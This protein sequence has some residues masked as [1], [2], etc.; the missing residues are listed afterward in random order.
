M[1]TTLSVHIKP[2]GE[3]AE[4]RPVKISRAVADF[5]QNEWEITKAINDDV[6]DGLAVSPEFGKRHVA[7]FQF[8]A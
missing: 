6:N 5:S 4:T 3:G 7:A 8:E 1:L 2:A